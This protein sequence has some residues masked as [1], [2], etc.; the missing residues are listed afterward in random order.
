LFCDWTALMAGMGIA[1]LDRHISN[2]HIETE[3]QCGKP[4]EA[5][6]P[7]IVALGGKNPLETIV[8]LCRECAELWDRDQS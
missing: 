4:I 8:P 6:R 2:R 3:C 7:A 5:L 1:P